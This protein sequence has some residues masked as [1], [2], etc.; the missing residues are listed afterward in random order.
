MEKSHEVRVTTP[1]LLPWE[2]PLPTG[3]SVREAVARMPGWRYDADSR[4][5][6]LVRTWKTPDFNSAMASLPPIG[7][8]A[9]RFGHRPDLAL[10][11][12]YLRIAWTTHD[13]GG[14]HAN[15]LLLAAATSALLERLT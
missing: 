1:D 6:C 9:E 8:L 5:P 2:H 12:G 3:D 14:V 4:P 15:D 7:E 10:G 11:W 13:R